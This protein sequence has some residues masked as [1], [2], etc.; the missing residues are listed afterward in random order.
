MSKRV[1]VCIAFAWWTVGI[2]AIL[3]ALSESE[4]A[5]LA[6]GIWVT[7]VILFFAW[8][9]KEIEDAVK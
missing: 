7:T 8:G 6:F 2:L 5:Y 9:I 4:W 1:C 3:D